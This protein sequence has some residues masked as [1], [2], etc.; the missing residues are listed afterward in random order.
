MIYIYTGG[1]VNTDSADK[2]EHVNKSD[3]HIFVKKLI[4]KVILSR[5]FED[6]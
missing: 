2:D 6:S 4:S 1:K 3:K 5:E